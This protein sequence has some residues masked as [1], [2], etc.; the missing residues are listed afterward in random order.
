MKKLD[1]FEFM[2]IEFMPDICFDSWLYEK[3][4]EAGIEYNCIAVPTDSLKIPYINHGLNLYDYPSIKK[5]GKRVYV[6]ELG[7]GDQDGGSSTIFQTYDKIGSEIAL[8][9][10]NAFYNK[11]L[12]LSDETKYVLYG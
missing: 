11:E 6:V 9:L 12:N 3:L 4:E 7:V 10:R 2:E 5:D 1:S 8:A